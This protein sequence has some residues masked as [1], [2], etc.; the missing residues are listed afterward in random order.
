M[1]GGAPPPKKEKP[2]QG[3]KAP[4]TRETPG[5]KP[6]GQAVEDML[7]EKAQAKAEAQAGEEQ[8]KTEEKAEKVVESEKAAKEAEEDDSVVSEAPEQVVFEAL[9]DGASA[10]PPLAGECTAPPSEGAAGECGAPSE[11]PKDEL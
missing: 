4:K 8:R 10:S 7:A 5:V 6:M 1:M 11:R 2:S 9:K 3:E